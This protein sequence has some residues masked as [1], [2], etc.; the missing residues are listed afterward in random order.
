LDRPGAA[1][2]IMRKLLARAWALSR[3]SSQFEIWMTDVTFLVEGG[4]CP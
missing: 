4:C 3:V 2:P 1:P